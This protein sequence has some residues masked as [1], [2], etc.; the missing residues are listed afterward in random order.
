MEA[1]LAGIRIWLLQRENRTPHGISYATGCQ[2]C[3]ATKAKQSDTGTAKKALNQP[4]VMYIVMLAHMGRSRGQIVITTPNR[5]RPQQAP[6]K[7]HPS[8]V[9]VRHRKQK[10]VTVP[11][12]KKK[13]AM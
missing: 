1:K 6:K 3:K 10:G 5:A 4:S 9:F 2:E 7:V 8:H 12:I 11:G 13:I